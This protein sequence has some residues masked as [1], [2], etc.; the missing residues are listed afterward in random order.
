[1][2]LNVRIFISSP[3]CR[4]IYVRLLKHSEI[5]IKFH[6]L[7][8]FYRR[9]NQK[10][11]KRILISKRL[12]INSCVFIFFFLFIFYGGLVNTRFLQEFT[13]FLSQIALSNVVFVGA[14]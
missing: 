7:L 12:F 9:S 4:F 1:M 2:L 13:V 6:T 14:F 5:I 11:P 10:K 8:S 3:S